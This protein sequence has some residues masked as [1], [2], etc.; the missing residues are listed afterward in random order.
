MLLG[1]DWHYLR[2][3]KIAKKKISVEC[4]LYKLKYSG[5]AKFILPAMFI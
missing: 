2:L 4:S 5:P 1:L 3:K